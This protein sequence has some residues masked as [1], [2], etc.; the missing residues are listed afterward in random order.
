[1]WQLL[2]LGTCAYASEQA[3]VFG[4]TGGGIDRLRFFKERLG[5]EANS[6]V[7]VGAHVGNWT[8]EAR[9]VFPSARFLMIEANALHRPELQ[10]VGVPFEIALLTAQGNQSLRFHSTRYMD[11]RLSETL[12]IRSRTLDDVVKPYFPACCDLIKADVQGAELELLLGGLRSLQRA[13]LVLLEAPVLPYNE[14]APRFSDL[15]AFMASKGFEVVD[16]ADATYAEGVS[17]V[18]H[19]DLLFAPRHSRLLRLPLP[20][21]IRPA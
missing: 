8:R 11:P 13:Q 18:L 5:F 6:I 4:W 14:G 9:Q 3:E 10:R 17:R 16:V 20:G 2:V 12:L 1:M 7:D 15:I 21:G 19:L